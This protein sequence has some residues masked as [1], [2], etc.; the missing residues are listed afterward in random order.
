MKVMEL[1]LTRIG[2]SRDIR[3]PAG[4]I[5]KH[6]L[7]RGIL[8]EERDNDVVLRP[9]RKSAKLFWEETAKGMAASDEDWSDW[10]ALPDSTRCTANLNQR[11]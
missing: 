7:E 9:K 11:S 2:N 1:K 4:L 8:L 10:E 5:A 6:H 3:L